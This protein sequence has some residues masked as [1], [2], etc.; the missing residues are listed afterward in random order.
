[1]SHRAGARASSAVVSISAAPIGVTGAP[2]R[3]TRP[4]VALT[5]SSLADG[6][7]DRVGVPPT[8]AYVS[9]TP[10]ASATDMPASAMREILGLHPPS[11]SCG[12]THDHGHER[13]LGALSQAVF[14]ERSP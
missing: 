3:E 9:V 14:G 10:V 11:Q 8:V 5:L 7:R 1:M 2:Q 4:R 12:A 13:A 6:K